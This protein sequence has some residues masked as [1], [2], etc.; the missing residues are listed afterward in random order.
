MRYDEAAG[1]KKIEHALRFTVVRTRRAYV[2]PARHFASRSDDRNLP[3]MG[4]RVRLKAG[5]DISRFGPIEQ[6]ILIALKKYGMDHRRQRQ[7]LVPQ[8]RPR[9]AVGRRSATHA[10]PHQ[11]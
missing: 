9:P 6:V 5:Y 7:R 2:P 3:P 10:Y 8:R 4:M 11:G 1:R